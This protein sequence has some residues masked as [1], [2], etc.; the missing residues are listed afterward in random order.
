MSKAQEMVDFYIDLEMKVASSKSTS[1]NG[2]VY[3]RQ[4]LPD[5]IK[6]REGWE[7]RVITERSGGASHSLVR[8]V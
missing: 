4:D 2:R 7:R 6:A 5:I 8:F 3:T 1:F